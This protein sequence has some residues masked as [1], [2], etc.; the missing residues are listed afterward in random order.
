L[1]DLPNV[2]F[3]GRAGAGKDTA[4]ELLTETLGYRRLAFADGLK[5]I[6]EE[7]WPGQGDRDL[8]QWFGNLVREAPVEEGDLT[9]VK[10]A[11][12]KLI[13][14]GGRLVLPERTKNGRA[15]VETYHPVAITDCRY[16]NEAWELKGEEF[17]IIR[18]AADRGDR[19]NRLRSN[20]KLGADGW[21][22]HISE[23]DLD[24]WPQDYTVY[25]IGTKADLLHDLASVITLERQAEAA[26]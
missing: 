16:R 6:A 24:T 15:T 26:R 25:N 4:A 12:R 5:A 20:G 13:R 8:W 23:T 14:K 10:Y 22:S 3:I 18:V 19:I 2:A 21:E 11:R 17:I 1:T 9:W 7:L